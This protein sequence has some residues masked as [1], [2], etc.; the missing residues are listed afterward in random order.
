[1]DSGDELDHSLS[2][3]VIE[4]CHRHETLPSLELLSTVFNSLKMV[5]SSELHKI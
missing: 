1:M 5:T 3:F 4:K 2:E